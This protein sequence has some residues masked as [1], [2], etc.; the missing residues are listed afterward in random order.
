MVHVRAVENCSQGQMVFVELIVLC[1]LHTLTKKLLDYL[2]QL[3][4]NL[5]APMDPVAEVLLE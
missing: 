5:S 2:A 4:P 3:P 1:R